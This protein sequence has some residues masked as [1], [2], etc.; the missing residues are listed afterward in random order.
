MIKRKDSSYLEPKVKIKEVVAN[1]YKNTLIYAS[2]ESLIEG[3][4]S[5]YLNRNSDI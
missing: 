2:D 3:Y 4:K 5:F 1:N